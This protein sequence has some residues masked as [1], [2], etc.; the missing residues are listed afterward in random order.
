MQIQFRSTAGMIKKT[1]HLTCK[2]CHVDLPTLILF[3][4]QKISSYLICLSHVLC[5]VY[6]SIKYITPIA[7]IHSRRCTKIMPMHKNN[8]TKISV[9][10]D[11]ILPG[12][13]SPPIQCANSKKQ[14]NIVSFAYTLVYLWSCMYYYLFYYHSELSL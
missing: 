4:G 2:S 5:N 9:K 3:G 10:R 6:T 8:F 14:A 12:N 1:Q 11:I 7:T 13:F